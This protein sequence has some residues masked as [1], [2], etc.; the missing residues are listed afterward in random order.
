MTEPAAGE[1]AVAA[2]VEQ[3]GGL[4]ILVNNV[5][6]GHLANGF[7]D[8]SDSHW[9]EVLDL[10]LMAA[11]RTTRAALP[12]LLDGGGV[13]VN[14]SSVNGHLPSASIYSYSAGKAA[15]NNLTVGLSQEYA[16]R[17]VRVVGVAP[18][19][20]S[21]PL[22]LGPSGAAATIAAR[23]GSDPQEVIDEAVTGIPVGRFTTPEEV[24][25]LVAFLA[26]ARAGTITGT[27]IRID[28]G[29]TPSV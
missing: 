20:V 9:L 17:G 25:D 22:W 18:G 5:G 6:I 29:I 19:P 28:G 13:I 12:H 14:V 27:T 21:T 4:D 24:G 10:N 26:S 2:T 1:R 11:V 8:E 7:A 23:T 3:L 16:P 15:M